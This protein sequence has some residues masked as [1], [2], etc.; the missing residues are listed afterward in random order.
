MSVDALLST[1]DLVKEYPSP[2]RRKQSPVRALDVV[3]LA[4]QAGTRTA[5]VGASGSGK[6]TLARCLVCLERPSSGN[7]RLN[8]QEL[9]NLSHRALRCVRPQLQLVFQD[10]A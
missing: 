6:S 3:S 10:A 2:G 9:T 8:G 1:E 7:I 5:I 4:I